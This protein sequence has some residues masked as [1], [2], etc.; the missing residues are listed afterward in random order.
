MCCDWCL[1]ALLRKAFFLK[2]IWRHLGKEL[3]E[4]L[5][6]YLHFFFKKKTDDETSNI[7]THKRY[8]LSSS[9]PPKQ[10][11]DS[12]LVLRVV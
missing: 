3:D 11:K 12:L 1:F 9:F 4:T 10:K 5:F 2:N 8:G 7:I 6:I